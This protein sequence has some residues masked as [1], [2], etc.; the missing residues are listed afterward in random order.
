MKNTP[1]KEIKIDNLKFGNDRVEKAIA[2]LRDVVDKL[3]GMTA[4]GFENSENISKERFEKIDQ[5]IDQ[6]FDG[7]SRRIDD[8]AMNRSTREE[9]KIL[10]MRVDRIEKALKIK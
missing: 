8:L 9:T 1:K 7:L 10:E 5:K 4:R 6:R 2:K 3:A